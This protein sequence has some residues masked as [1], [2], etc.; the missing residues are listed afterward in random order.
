MLWSAVGILRALS[1]TSA[2]D[3]RC[4][5]KAHG[6]LLQDTP[7][8]R[9]VRWFLEDN[10][11]RRLK[12]A[13]ERL[14]TGG[15]PMSWGML[16]LACQLITGEID[17]SQELQATVCREPHF[18]LPFHLP[19]F[20]AHTFCAHSSPT[21]VHAPQRI[22]ALLFPDETGQAQ[23]KAALAGQNPR[24]ILDTEDTDTLPAELDTIL[25][26]SSIG[27]ERLFAAILLTAPSS[28]A[29]SSPS[30]ES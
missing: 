29:E 14:T 11:D 24:A 30:A 8:D 23:F 16:K 9:G 15:Y 2:D 22:S 21:H 3:E 26:Q 1:E 27:R 19:G 17:R 25:R 5:E 20:R 13:A 4:D 12:D 10:D 18:L 6:L 28:S 7:P